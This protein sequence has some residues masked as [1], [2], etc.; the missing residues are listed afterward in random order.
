[1]HNRRCIPDSFALL[2]YEYLDGQ[3]A[4][5]EQVLRHPRPSPTVNALDAMPIQTWASLLQRAADHLHDPQLGLHLGQTIAARH[6]GVLGYLVMASHTLG[7]ALTHIHHYQR[8]IYDVTPMLVRPQQTC[9]DL[10]WDAQHG[11]PGPLVDETA[12]TALLQ[13]GRTLSGGDVRPIEVHFINPRPADLQPYLDFFACPVL[14]AQAETLVRLDRATLQAPLNSADPAL[15]KLMQQQADAL[16][17]ALPAG[18]PVI[19]QVRRLIGRMPH[20]QE[21][22]IA[23]IARAV[24]LSPRTLQRRLREANT[25]L[26]DEIAAVRREIAERYLRETRLSL[27]DIAMLLGYSEHSA[28]TRSFRRWTGQSPR[29]YRQAQR[30]G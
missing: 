19:D 28:F 27:M 21:P 13:L 22:G 4:S 1:M 11:R 20:G 12:I 6:V 2:L 16:L 15:L 18:L 17:C 8:L 30:H 10:V 24:G 29:H 14:F 7:E 3:G 23:C 5:A 9:V 26:R 25:C